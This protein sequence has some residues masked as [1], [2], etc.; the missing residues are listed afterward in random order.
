MKKNHD[1]HQQ[2]NTIEIGLNATNIFK[3]NVMM[4]YIFSNFS[5]NKESG[6]FRLFQG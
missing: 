1:Y 4:K 2:Y 5:S 6:P 3:K